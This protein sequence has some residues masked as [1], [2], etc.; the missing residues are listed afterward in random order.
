MQLINVLG[1]TMCILLAVPSIL[2]PAW[3]EGG[4]AEHRPMCVI[5]FY[6]SCI[7]LGLCAALAATHAYNIVSRTSDKLLL[8]WLVFAINL[9]VYLRANKKKANTFTLT[10]IAKATPV[11]CGA[12]V[13]TTLACLIQQ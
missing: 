10:H 11:L 6:R 12:L 1:A 13:L 5:Q 9:A 3:S 7:V 2:P 4:S 8:T